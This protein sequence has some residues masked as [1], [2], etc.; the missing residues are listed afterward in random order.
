[1]KEDMHVPRILLIDDHSLVRAGIKSLI[2]RIEGFE[3]VA[4]ASSVAEA[5]SRLLEAAP[6]IVITDLSIGMDNGLD[7]VRKVR[8]MSDRTKLMILSMH[9]SEALVSE[10]LKLGASAYLLKE[11]APGELEI[12][13]RAVWRGDNFLSPAVSTK[14]IRRFMRPEDA[15]ADPLQSLTPRQ[16]EILTLLASGK[17]PKEIA[18]E[19]DLSIKTIAAHRAQIMERLKINDLVGLVLFAVKHGLIRV[20]KP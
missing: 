9:S 13:L 19:L 5:M 7:L 3:V 2:D 6:D 11:A 10:A 4:E 12:A 15:Q 14:M 1:M 16:I 20:D 17:G 18:Y 8:Q